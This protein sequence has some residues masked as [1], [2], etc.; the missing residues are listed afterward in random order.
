VKS[1]D[2][3]RPLFNGFKTIRANDDG[4]AAFERFMRVIRTGND[5]MEKSNSRKGGGVRYKIKY[6]TLRHVETTKTLTVVWR[7][8][9]ERL[10]VAVVRI[11]RGGGAAAVIVVSRDHHAVVSVYGRR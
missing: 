7:Q 4:P 5:R 8:R 6:Y 2:D 11:V 9:G 1:A 3:A 10:R